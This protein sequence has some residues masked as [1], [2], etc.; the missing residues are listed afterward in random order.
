MSPRER[1]PAQPVLFLDIDGVLNSG[2]YY[3][4]LTDKGE[5]A[6]S[7]VDHLDPAAIV[8]LNRLVAATGCEVVVS[9]TW[10][11]K[12]EL[13]RLWRMLRSRG[14]TGPHLI[15]KTPNFDGMMRQQE[16]AHWRQEHGKPAIYAILDD[17]PDA[18][19]QSGRFVKTTFDE[20]LTSELADRVI[21]LLT[22]K[23]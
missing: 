17:D 7:A 12:H 8:H 2:A 11:I 4:G 13:P 10:R 15:R 16:I 14:Y 22:G 21:A 23:P 20:G 6:E 3:K 5:G 18:D 9:S 1:N 19:D